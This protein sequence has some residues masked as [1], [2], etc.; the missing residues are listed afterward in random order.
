MERGGRGRGRGRV[1][2]CVRACVRACVRERKKK[3][4]RRK[5]KESRKR[6]NVVLRSKLLLGTQNS[7]LWLQ[8]SKKTAD[9]RDPPSSQIWCFAPHAHD[10]F[11]IC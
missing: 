8:Y 3:E 10:A 1:K 4:E 5:K 2:C 9:H 7:A 6:G 11:A